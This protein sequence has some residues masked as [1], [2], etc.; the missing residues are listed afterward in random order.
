MSIF[1]VSFINVALCSV[2]KHS[3]ENRKNVFLF[4]YFVLKEGKYFIYLWPR[5]YVV[6]VMY[7]IFF[8]KP[9]VCTILFCPVDTHCVVISH[10]LIVA[11][12]MHLKNCL[13]LMLVLL[14]SRFVVFWNIQMK[15]GKMCFF[16]FVLYLDWY[17]DTFLRQYLNPCWNKPECL[18]L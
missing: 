2:L 4:L 14:M 5:L 18:A 11:M 7:K 16:S 3:Y 8:I 10:M 12:S 1:N 6:I 9:N 15:T 17:H 13:F